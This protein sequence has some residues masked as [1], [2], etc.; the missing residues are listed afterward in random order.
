MRIV[1]G[2][3]TDTF[4]FCLR[5]ALSR[6]GYTVV[7]G[8]ANELTIKKGFSILYTVRLY[9]S[10]DYKKAKAVIIKDNQ[11]IDKAFCADRKMGPLAA[12]VVNIVL[13]DDSPKTTAA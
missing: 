12:A 3:M 11:H 6:L 13:K 10:N 4:E 9:Y 2:Q 8:N 1:E 7:S 5:Q